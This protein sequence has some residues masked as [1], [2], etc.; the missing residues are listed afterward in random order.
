MRTLTCANLAPPNNV[1]E[2]SKKLEDT[3]Q[4]RGCTVPQ[5]TI[6]WSAINNIMAN[7]K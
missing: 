4:V 1:K 7:Y 6:D 2:C 5:K 3:V